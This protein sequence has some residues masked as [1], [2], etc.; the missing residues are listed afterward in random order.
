MKYQPIQFGQV[1]RERRLLLGL[2]Q[3]QLARLVN[4]ATVTIRRLEGGTLRPS[5]QLSQLLAEAIEIPEDQQTGFVHLA[6]GTREPTALPS[7]ATP[8]PLTTTPVAQLA[9]PYH[10]LYAF[11][12]ADAHNFFGRQLLVQEMVDRLAESN[13]LACFLA[14]LGPSGSGK[15]SV[16]QAGLIPAL[17]RGALPGSAEWPIVTLTPGADPWAEL[18]AALGR[19]SSI[20]VPDLSQELQRDCEG[21]LRVS[22]RL[23]PAE[24]DAQLLLIIDQFEELFTL[25][26]AEERRQQF[27]ESL[28]IALLDADSP[29]RVVATLR[30]DF[31]DR[32]LQY[33]DFGEMLR[34]RMVLVVPL[35]PDELTQAITEPLHQLGM[36]MAPE[37]VAAIVHDIGG[38]PASLPLLQYALTEL[39][40]RRRGPLLTL[41][42]YQASGGV[43]GALAHRAD[44]IFDSFDPAGQAAIR[45]TF[46]RL[47]TLGEGVE[48]TRRRVLRPEIEALAG[49]NDASLFEQI[50]SQYGRHRLLTFD[51][52]P[53][54]HSPTVEVAHE[55]LL[56]EWPRLRGWLR[57][58]RDDI[59]RQRQLAEAA[60]Q[61]AANQQDESFLLRGNRLALFLAWA[62]ESS[63]SLNNHEVAFL[64]ASQIAEEYRQATEAARLQRELDI[65]RE[66]ATAESERATAQQRAAQ[67]LRQRAQILA[68]ALLLAVIL[69]A[70][71]IVFAR[72]ARA[73]EALAAQ[74]EAEARVAY[75]LSLAANARQAIAANDQQLALLL[76]LAANDVDNPPATAWQ[77]LVDIAYA[78]GVQRQLSYPTPLNTLAV[79]P[80]GRAL[81]TGS[82]DGLITVWDL[83]SGQIRGQFAGHRDAVIAIA[84]SPDG[85]QILS[86][87]RDDTAILWDLATGQIL[88]RLEG[89][90]GDV[91]GVAFGPD[92]TWAISAEDSAA[93]PGELIVWDLSSGQIL[94]RFGRGAGGNIEGILDMAL[95]PDGRQA[96]VSQFSFADNNERVVLLWDTITGRPL[97]TFPG[98]DRTVNSVTFG[99]DGRHGLAASSDASLYYWDLGSGQL[100]FQLQGHEG[101]VLAAA[102]S[103]DGR[104]ALSA[105]LDQQLIWW[106]LE[107]G[108]II[109]R[110]RTGTTSIHTLQ[111]LNDSQAI[112]AGADG[113]IR[114]W[115]LHNAWQ[116]ARWEGGHL[117]PDPGTENRGMGL[118]ISPDG[119]WALSGGNLPDNTLILWDYATGQ[120]LR[121]LEGHEGSIFDIAFT[122]DSRRALSASQDG[123]LIFW[124]LDSGQ[125][126][127]HWQA[128]SASVNSVEIS[129][130]GRFALS[131]SLD[132][133]V[134]Y[135]ELE[136][137]AVL[138]RLIGH[139][140]GRGVYDVAFLPGEQQAISSSW[141]GTLIAWDLST[142]EQIQRLTGLTG[143]V[144]HHFD[145]DGDP[146]IHGISLSP[147][148]TQ[149]L[150]GGRDNSLLLWELASGQALRRFIGH[151]DFIVDVAFTPDGLTAVS[152]AQNDPLLVWDVATGSPVRRLPINNRLNS[153]F[154]PTLAL[155]PDGQTM[156]ATDADGAILQWQLA[157]PAPGHLLDWIA[158]NRALREMSCAERVTYGV[159]PL[160][161]AG[162]PVTTAAE[163]LAA[164]QERVAN[165][166]QAIPTDTMTEPA[167]P[168]YPA[169]SSRP[170]QQATLGDN[171]GTLERNDF[172]IW[173]YEGRAGETLQFELLAQEPLTTTLLPLEERYTTSSLDT[174][175]FLINPDGTLLAK[176]NDAP[177][178]D[179]SLRTDANIEAIV[180]PVD[181]VYEI[182]ARS[183][184][185][186]NAGAY[187]LRITSRD[188]AA[189][190]A[191]LAEYAGHYLE[192]PWRY[193]AYI[194]VE[195]GQL[196]LFTP[197]VGGS[198][199]LITIGDNEFRYAD[200]SRIVFTRNEAGE[201]DG[202]RIWVSL[203]HPIGGHWYDAIRL[204]E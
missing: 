52:D 45:Q 156:L 70:V 132:G 53:A 174:L 50:L 6:R 61:W 176:A 91:S 15:S 143:G 131:G 158:K 30:A 108:R 12:E 39:F 60:R 14:V 112:T 191:L 2:T 1:L 177:G 129:S 34:Q 172:D 113:T 62:S 120:P 182:Q 196:I 142:G 13:E 56:R 47:A 139:Y 18:A 124:D 49:S 193:N 4:C 150:S 35:A 11:G 152:T 187:I 75:S 123:S 102:I 20:P 26:T 110:L 94:R 145:S 27:L 68:A 186:A 90:R 179:G 25:V 37:L 95:S 151:A 96:L 167:T 88:H 169:K 7:Q 148:G 99:P 119:R 38:Q 183:Y 24:S 189:D 202:Y 28:L 92:G 103:P 54:T 40:E 192:G 190:P 64:G 204:E 65:A 199:V 32:P 195:A 8:A 160:C 105:S 72:Q 201:V 203:V 107:T 184:L 69:T 185:D 29:L 36:A 122:P 57:G 178:D 48:D 116:L 162:Q 31:T 84:Y 126:L 127:A 80:D 115:D 171:F 109:Q 118:A 81:L 9:N 5:V 157:A 165:Q 141:D 136:S 166:P 138:Q 104:S 180:L 200:G 153:A 130:D 73:N 63:L 128:N 23:L 198:Y 41:A 159:E 114:I 67:S 125:Q 44:E 33:V 155:H 175:L 78:P 111:F 93:A 55:A 97:Q 42:D 106:D 147:A 163:L 98:L 19:V 59:R 46:L 161:V 66:L 197:E 82:D 16:V 89:H 194:H 10:G 86:G 117:P 154:R 74:R 77:T 43:T 164:L 100:L 144:G 133:D 121:Q 58:S 170:A 146:G 181:G 173:H 134:V 87:S 51:H 79:S 168:L 21:L 76:A 71:A 22:H 149:L 188:Y 135:W 140:E 101:G 85:Q 137:G 3:A 83:D 17:R